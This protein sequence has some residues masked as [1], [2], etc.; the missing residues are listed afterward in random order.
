MYTSGRPALA[1]EAI[2]PGSGERVG[3][4]VALESRAHHGQGFQFLA[5]IRV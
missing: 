5:L 1:V 2:L 3:E 4:K